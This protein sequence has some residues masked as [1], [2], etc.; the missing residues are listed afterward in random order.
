MVL[1]PA[2][3]NQGAVRDE[4]WNM[5]GLVLLHNGKDLKTQNDKILVKSH[6]AN[7]PADKNSNNFTGL[8]I[9]SLSALGE[10]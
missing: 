8:G 7:F 1:I 3:W 9:V 6:E 4:E 10:C 5:E 2:P